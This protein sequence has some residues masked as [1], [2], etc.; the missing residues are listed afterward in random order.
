M[1]V[2]AIPGSAKVRLSALYCTIAS[3][4]TKIPGIQDLKINPGEKQKY[5]VQDLDSDFAAS[6]PAGTFGEGTISGKLLWNPLGTVHKFLHSTFN[7]VDADAIAANNKT[8]IVGKIVFGNTA[9]EYVAKYFFTKFE[10][11]GEMNGAFM[12][13]WEA[14]LTDRIELN[15][16]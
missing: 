9:V 11:S 15:E 6:L 7:D 14:A 10:I 12:V 3:T 4:L 1:T 8:K 5:S 2:A 13:D 16:S